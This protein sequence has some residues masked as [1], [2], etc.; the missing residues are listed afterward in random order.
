MNLARRA[1]SGISICLAMTLFQGCISVRIKRPIKNGVV[2]S[3]RPPMMAT[4]EQ[5]TAR[6]ESAANQIKSFQ[7]T[8]D[9]TPST[10]S[11]YQGEITEY[12]DFGGYILF[13]QPD[14][15]RIIGQFPIVHNTAFDM[16]SDGTTFKVS[17]PA[18]SLFVFG[19]NAAPTNSSN[20][21]ENWRPEALLEAMVIRPINLAKEKVTLLDFTDEDHSFYFLLVQRSDEKG[22]IVPLRSIWFNRVDLEIAR[23]V[24]Y[25]PDANTVSDT[26]YSDWTDFSGIRFPK[27]IDINRPIDGYGVVIDIEKMDMNVALTDQQFVLQQPAG[28]KLQVIGS[29]PGAPSQPPAQEKTE[30]GK[31]PNK[32]VPDKSAK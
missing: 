4:R 18:K 12:R 26:R 31:T 24:V 14:E 7:A 22:N 21:L 27:T 6:I 1:I 10:G 29:P 5:L 17:I 32:T 28:S 30:P 16:V 23:Q 3:K 8:V 15:I 13:R 9:M 2:A 11:V 19:E 25:A 20:K